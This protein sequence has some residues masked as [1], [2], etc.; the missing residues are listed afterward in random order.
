MFIKCSVSQQLKNTKVFPFISNRRFLIEKEN[1]FQIRMAGRSAIK[2]FQFYQKMCQATGIDW[3][4][5]QSA[6]NSKNLIYAFS[7]V[8]L[9]MALLAHVLFNAESISEIGVN[10]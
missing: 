10:M 6:L 5:D 1:I 8:Q 7:M 9:A 2:L 3:N 4:P